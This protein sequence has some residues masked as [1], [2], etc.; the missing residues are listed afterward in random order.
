MANP[1]LEAVQIA[2][3]LGSFHLFNGSPYLGFA[4]FGS[5][6]RCAQAIGLHRQPRGS[7][8]ESCKVWWALEIADKYAAVA[9]GLPCG[10]DESD[11]NV[12]ETDDDR[13]QIFSAPQ[14]SGIVTSVTYH[15]FKARLYR[16]MGSF[17]GR[18]RQTAQGRTVMDVHG[19]L[20]EWYKSVPS[21][22]KYDGRTHA[23]SDRPILL[24]MQTLCLQLAY[25]NLQMVL[26]RQAVFPMD[27]QGSAPQRAEN[28]RKLSQ[29]ATRTA[30]IS[31]LDTTRHICRSSHASIHAGLCSFTAGIV[32][33]KLLAN[34]TSHQERE[35]WT[36]SLRNIITFFENFPSENYRFATQSL[37]LLRALEAHVNPQA[38][39]IAPEE[40]MFHSQAQATMFNNVMEPFGNPA[41]SAPA[42]ISLT[43]GP[44]TDG[45]DFAST[46]PLDDVGQLWLW[47]DNGND[48]WL[49]GF[50]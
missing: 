37:M 3:L 15:Q 31:T 6:I 22:L 24:Q 25:D 14:S 1:T 49:S 46:G 34:E 44:G 4:I 36:E 12:P 30:N 13:A 39:L 9:F 5:G 18:R 26:F 42:D 27:A 23:F 17:L 29:S 43:I 41:A 8:A 21:A 32:L 35:S 50:S 28:I 10:I 2:I 19:E 11:C 40:I 45:I 33:C 38:S 16:I 7:T 48:D 47:A 20:T